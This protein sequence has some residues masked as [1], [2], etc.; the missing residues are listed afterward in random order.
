[1]ILNYLVTL[2]AVPVAVVLYFAGRADLALIFAGL[3]AV[4]GLWAAGPFSAPDPTTP[5]AEDPDVLPVVICPVCGAA[6]AFPVG[7]DVVCPD[8][9]A[10]GTA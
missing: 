8:C 2:I 3:S 6:D 1:M 7:Q 4:G 10:V 5:P 9:L